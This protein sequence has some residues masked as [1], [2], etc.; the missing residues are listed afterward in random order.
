MYDLPQENF[1]TFGC[2]SLDSVTNGG[3]IC[4]KITEIYGES[5]SGKTQIALQLAL[6]AQLPQRLNGTRKK[7]IY[8][9]T[10]NSFPIKRMNQMIVEMN[11]KYR[12]SQ[13]NYTENVLISHNLDSVSNF[14]CHK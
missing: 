4:G 10:E 6:N 9:C 5:G 8:I 13:I 1:I 2:A 14:I 12:R 7:S 3:I 11:K